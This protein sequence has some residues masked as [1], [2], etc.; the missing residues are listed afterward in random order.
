MENPYAY[1]SKADPTPATSQLSDYEAAIGPN[2]GYYLKRFE[3]L[4]AGGPRAG[5][6]WPAFFATPFWFVYRKMWLPGLL[7]FF[8]PF[9]AIVVG[10]ILLAVLRPGLVVGILLFVLLLA[11]PP[12]LLPIFA[13]AIY[14]RHVRRLI[15]GLPGSIAQVPDRRQAR[16]ERDGG[17]SVGGVVGVAVAGVFVYVFLLGVLAAIS[18]PAYQDYTIRAQI[19]E[20]LNLASG[21]KAEVAEFRAQ[22]GAWPE[23]ADVGSKMPIGKYVTAVEVSAGSVVITYGNDANKVLAGQR[24][25][26]LPG[27]DAN[28]DLFWACGNAPMP[29]GFTPGDGPYGSDVP[30]KYLPANCRA[31]R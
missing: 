4:D 25:A 2:T 3:D 23:Q 27:I 8:W 20:G 13:N 11:A 12:I 18:I 9:I 31:P 7:A 22:Q 1:T 30:D 6:H 16:L 14:W 15:E 17:T 24:V 26:L 10:S 29:G 19:M 28:G 5:W 21:V